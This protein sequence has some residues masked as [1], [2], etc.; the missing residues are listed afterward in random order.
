MAAAAKAIACKVPARL[1]TRSQSSG[2]SRNQ[3]L[4]IGAEP[5]ERC[6]LGHAPG[7]EDDPAI[8]WKTVLLQTNDLAQPAPDTVPMDGLADCPRQGKAETW[9]VCG[10][11]FQTKCG[12]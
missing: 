12:E 11:T 7:V 9:P 6:L 4:D 5:I 1:S 8:G 10:I 3:L 2:T